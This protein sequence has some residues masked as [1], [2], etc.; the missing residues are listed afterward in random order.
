MKNDAEYIE[1]SHEQGS[2][3]LQ[4]NDKKKIFTWNKRQII[5]CVEEK[6]KISYIYN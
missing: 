4:G 1:R 2:N 6:I 3:Y 5:S